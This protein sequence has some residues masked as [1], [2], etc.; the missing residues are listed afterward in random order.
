MFYRKQS[1]KREVK[2]V[3]AK[4]SIGATGAPTLVSSEGV[5]SIVRN[6]AGNYTITL[7]K[8]YRNF[9]SANVCHLEADAENLNFQFLAE[10]VDG[11]KTVSFLCKKIVE[12]AATSYSDPDYTTTITSTVTPT[13]PSSGSIL[14]ISLNLQN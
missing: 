10:D 3:F 7:R 6:S 8:K 14:Y 4:V 1:S 11:A 5:A 12:T 9:V 13:D 2:E